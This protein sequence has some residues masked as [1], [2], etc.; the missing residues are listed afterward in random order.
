MHT[1]DI[2]KCT[3][4]AEVYEQTNELYDDTRMWLEELINCL[5]HGGALEDMDRAMEELCALYDMNVP[6]HSPSKPAVGDYFQLATKLLTQKPY[7][8]NK[9]V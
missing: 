9:E 6:K 4:P 1:Y 2:W 3:D 5:Y 8:K 7:P